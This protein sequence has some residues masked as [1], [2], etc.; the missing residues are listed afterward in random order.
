MRY[1]IKPEK[2][3]LRWLLRIDGSPGVLPEFPD[4]N[5]LGLV[6]VHLISG[7]T[8]AEVIPAPAHVK[9]ACGDGLPLGRLYFQ[10]PKDRLYSVCPDLTPDSFSGG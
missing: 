2:P 6:V 7:A 1:F 8:L 10:I 3:V 4:D 9:T 5:R